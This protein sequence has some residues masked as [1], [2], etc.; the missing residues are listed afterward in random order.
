MGCL[1]AFRISSEAEEIPR[2]RMSFVQAEIEKWDESNPPQPGMRYAPV[3]AKEA[4][5]AKEKKDDDK[6]WGIPLAEKRDEKRGSAEQKEKPEVAEPAT[7]GQKDAEAKVQEKE[8]DAVAV[9]PTTANAIKPAKGR[10]VVTEPK[11][12]GPLNETLPERMARL[13]AEREARDAKEREAEARR[14]SLLYPQKSNDE[15]WQ[16][17][18]DEFDKYER[19]YDANLQKAKK[20]RAE[21]EAKYQEDCLRYQEKFLRLQEE[22][23]RGRTARNDKDA[24]SAVPKTTGDNG[25]RPEGQTYAK[26]QKEREDKMAKELTAIPHLP[27]ETSGGVNPRD[28]KKSSDTMPKATFGKNVTARQ[29]LPQEKTTKTSGTL[30]KTAGNK[31]GTLAG[32]FADRRHVQVGRRGTSM[33]RKKNQRAG[34]G[35][36]ARPWLK[37]DTGGDKSF[38]KANIKRIK[39]MEKE[40]GLDVEDDHED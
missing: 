16:E 33:C 17:K 40:A 32:S 5:K 18:M 4:T 25:K 39:E 20:K 10:V 15:I 28:A 38:I 23:K 13:V 3:C 9:G 36:Q 6:V 1:P 7:A 30:A 21:E 24:S 11:R 26:A 35:G 27:L 37:L 31:M 22:K 8:A 29:Q 34:G 19:D 12:Y 2:A 14:R